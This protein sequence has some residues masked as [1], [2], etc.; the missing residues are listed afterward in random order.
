MGK[1]WDQLIGCEGKELRKAGCYARGKSQVQ[2]TEVLS[3]GW[4][5]RSMDAEARTYAKLEIGTESAVTSTLPLSE[6]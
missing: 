1:S 2:L 6:E 4:R 5:R 3:E